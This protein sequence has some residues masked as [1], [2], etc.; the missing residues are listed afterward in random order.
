MNSS[1]SHIIEVWQCMVRKCT[2]LMT[3]NTL[4]TPLSRHTP[5][6]VQP[7]VNKSHKWI[8][9]I[10]KC[11]DQVMQAHAHNKDRAI[12]SQILRRHQLYLSVCTEHKRVHVFVADRLGSYNCAFCF[13][14]VKVRRKTRGESFKKNRQIKHTD[15][16]DR[17]NYPSG[18]KFDSL[19]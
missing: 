2:H 1:H 18:I 5:T 15:Q 3:M 13:I 10:H 14:P 17:S 4:L 19:F 8:K 16:K 6:T 12:L 7:H 11:M 9:C